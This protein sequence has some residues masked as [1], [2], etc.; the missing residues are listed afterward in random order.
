MTYHLSNET[1]DF[2]TTLLFKSLSIL[3]H[4]IIYQTLISS[5][6]VLEPITS[7]L[8]NSPAILSGSS[9]RRIVP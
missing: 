2:S 9:L 6:N 1:I 7:L 5:L 8:L 4:N 3:S